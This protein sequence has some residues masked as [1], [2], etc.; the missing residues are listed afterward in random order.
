MEVMTT[1]ELIEALGHE[2][3]VLEEEEYGKYN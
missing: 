3:K 2:I 1:R